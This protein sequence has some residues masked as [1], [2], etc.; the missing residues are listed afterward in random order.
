M[1]TIGRATLMRSPPKVGKRKLKIR[2]AT[3]AN[4]GVNILINLH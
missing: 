1:K 4:L 3:Q 2:F